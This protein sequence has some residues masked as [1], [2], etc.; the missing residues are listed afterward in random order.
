MCIRDSPY[1]STKYYMMVKGDDNV[2]VISSDLVTAFS[3]TVDDMKEEETTTV[4]ETTT[5]KMC[6]R[7]RSYDMSV[8]VLC[9]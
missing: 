9:I 1:D 2:Y 4:E 6:I 8:P 7:D 5:G 3:K